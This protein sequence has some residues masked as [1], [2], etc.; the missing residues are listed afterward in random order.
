[1]AFGSIIERDEDNSGEVS[2]PLLVENSQRFCMFPLKYP[3]IWE[4]YKKAEASFWTGA[5]IFGQLIDQ[6]SF[7][8]TSYS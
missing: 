6:T 7:S 8:I 5:L 3:E 1:M 2:E 4:M